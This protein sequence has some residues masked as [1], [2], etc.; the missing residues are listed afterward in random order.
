MTRWDIGRLTNSTDETDIAGLMSSNSIF[1]IPYFQRKYTWGSS[2]LKQ[3]EQD[4]LRVVDVAGDVH[5]LGAIII[6]GRKSNPSD[7]VI[8]DVI[9][10]QQRI[11]TLFL[12]LCGLVKLLSYLGDASGAANLFL[13]CLVIPRDTAASSNVKLHPCKD[14]RGQLNYVISDL[15]SDA[16]LKE[17]LG[18]LAV[19]RLPSTGG[20]TGTLRNNYRAIVRFLEKQH[21]EAG[22]ERIRAIIKALLESLSVV[23]IDVKDPTN[24]PKIFNSLN[25]QHEPMTIGDL[26]RNEIFSRVANE[27]PDVIEQIDQNRWRPF[28]EKFQHDR[29]NLFDS[30]FFPY[31]LI[32]DHNLKKSEVFGSLRK[33]WADVND[34]EKIIGE[35][36]AYQNAFIDLCCGTNLQNLDDPVRSL[37]ESLRLAGAPGSTYPFLMQLSNG[38][39]DG[40]ISAEVGSGVLETVESFLVRR[41]ICGHEPTGL[42]AVF[43]RLWVD[44]EGHPTGED[45]SKWLRERRTVAWPSDDEVRINIENR[46]LYGAGITHFLLR[47]YDKSL[48]GDS[49]TMPG[50]IEHVLPEN[51]SDEWWVTF[52]Q[53]ECSDL[54][55]L[56]G[57]LVILTPPMNKELSN[58]PYRLKKPRY[59]DDSMFK[60][61][62]ELAREYETWTPQDIATH[63]YRINS[64][65]VDGGA[66]AQANSSRSNNSV[67]RCLRLNR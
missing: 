40:T 13:M 25:S 57:N 19:K 20:T 9:D 43:K 31:G 51:P 62:R 4:L 7:P 61:T 8:Y 36:E 42:H 44:C 55:H 23:Q 14:D 2:R 59:Q 50:E 45:V 11:T 6:H 30:Y 64:A 32:L 39:R 1:A 60:S 10:G 54:Q 15:L 5:F 16:G 58:D 12:F 56:L 27:H 66:E 17:K 38:L 29:Q 49:P 53:K 33:R 48:G 47:Q 34:P 35:L 46:P 18:S 63:D 37:F 28:Y 22:V 3:M 65:R 21:K 41:A 26:V 24:G 67:S 52:S